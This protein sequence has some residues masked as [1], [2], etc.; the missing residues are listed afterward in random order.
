MLR[1]RSLLH[2]KG[3]TLVELMIGLA[4]VAVTLA[5]AIPSYS[6][7]ILNAKLR[8]AAESMQTGLQL[9]RA[10]AVSRNAPVSLTMG[11]GSSWTVGCVTTTTACPATIQSRATGDGSSTAVTVSSTATTITFDNLGRMTAPVPATGVTFTQI[12]FGIDPT[13]QAASKTRNLNVTVSISGSVRLCD[14]NTS[15]P[16]PRAC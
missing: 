7:W 2:I 4:I 9:A 10:E 12:S 11:T 8:T 16:D 13:K 6:T 3:F 14:P 15:S 5:I 1:S